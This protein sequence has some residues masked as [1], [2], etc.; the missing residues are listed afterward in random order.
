MSLFQSSNPKEETHK[1]VLGAFSV[2]NIK[3]EPEDNQSA[4][5]IAKRYP[6]EDFPNGS[7]L[8]VAQSQMAVFTNN[9]NAGDSISDDGSGVV[10]FSS[11]SSGGTNS[12]YFSKTG[13][14]PG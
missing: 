9:M 10:A 13:T 3:W 6:Y 4:A 1:G 12:S 2:D 14:S 8:Q 7:Y 5:I 11:T